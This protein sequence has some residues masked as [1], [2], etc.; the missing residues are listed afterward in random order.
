MAEN[1]KKPAEGKY[2][3]YQGKPLVRE[4][5]TIC[6]GDLQDKYFLILDIIGYK[7][8]NGQKIPDNIIVQ[9]VESANPSNI[10]KQATKQGLTA[11]MELGMVWLD[12]ANKDS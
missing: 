10:L 7:T 4:G 11:A 12:R 8:E 3:T 5:E 1:E 6:Y 9:I 2:I